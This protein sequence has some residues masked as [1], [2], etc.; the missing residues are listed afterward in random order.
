MTDESKDAPPP[1]PPDVEGEA[2]KQEPGGYAPSPAGHFDFYQRAGGIVTPLIT[3]IL[4][5]FIGGLVV[6]VTTGNNPLSTYKAIFNGTGLNWFFQV[7][8]YHVGGPFTNSTVWFPWDTNSFHSHSAY[9]LQTTLVLTTA[10]IFTGLAV[11]FA[12]RCGLFNIGGQGQYMSGAIVAVWIGGSFA[13]M[14]HFP[15]AVLTL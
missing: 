8:S 3:T 9:N 4:A 2:P 1:P 13:G 10:L 15:H 11:A 5:F 14:A 7:G 6:L 12:F